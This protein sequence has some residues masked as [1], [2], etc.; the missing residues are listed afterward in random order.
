M[1]RFLPAALLALGVLAGCSSSS[2]ILTGTQTSVVVQYDGKDLTPAMQ[3]ATTYCGALGKQAALQGV[4]Q[5]NGTGVATFSC[6]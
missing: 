6:A 3:R 1:M 5:D 4:S 2:K